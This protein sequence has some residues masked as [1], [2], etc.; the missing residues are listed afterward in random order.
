M[1]VANSSKHVTNNNGTQCTY[2]WDGTKWRQTEACA[3]Q[4]CP[5]E[6]DL[7]GMPPGDGEP[8]QFSIPCGTKKFP[9]K[10][11]TTT[12]KKTIDRSKVT[13]LP[14]SS[15]TLPLPPAKAGN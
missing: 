15:R 9:T 3:S 14:E 13:P 1:P 4:D 11:D 12:K 10:I 2:E 8:L 7:G 6:S 5:P